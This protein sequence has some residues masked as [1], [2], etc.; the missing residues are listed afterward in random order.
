MIDKFEFGERREKQNSVGVTEILGPTATT[1]P[2][3]AIRDDNELGLGSSWLQ[4][5]QHLG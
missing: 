3:T 1:H 2:H 4:L 5:G